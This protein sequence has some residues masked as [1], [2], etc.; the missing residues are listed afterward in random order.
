MATSTESL[1]ELKTEEDL[2]RANEERRVQEARRSF[3]KILRVKEKTKEIVEIISSV[4][5]ENILK[6]FSYN[7]LEELLSDLKHIEDGIKQTHNSVDSIHNHLKKRFFPSKKQR[8]FMFFS[9]NKN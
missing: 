6:T 1:E 9:R 4:N 5:N 2:N 7:D 3:Q 8:I